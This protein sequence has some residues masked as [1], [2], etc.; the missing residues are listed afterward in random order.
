MKATNNTFQTEFNSLPGC[1]V[2]IRV[3]SQT[4]KIGRYRSGGG[5]GG[6]SVGTAGPSSKGSLV[7][8]AVDFKSCTG[9]SPPPKWK[10]NKALLSFG[11]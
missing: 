9:P 6:G 8:V 7:S 1:H 5:G 3:Q 11:S 4:M 10:R 2:V